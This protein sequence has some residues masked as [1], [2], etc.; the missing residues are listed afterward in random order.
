M[1]YFSAL[2]RLARTSCTPA[3]LCLAIGILAAAAVSSVVLFSGTMAAATVEIVVNG[4]VVGIYQSVVR[5]HITVDGIRGPV[6]IDI[7]AGG[8]AVTSADCP[9][10]ICRRTGRIH[11]AGAMIVCVPN[12]L[13][14]HL[15]GA[16]D[17]DA[18]LITY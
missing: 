4:Q 18:P 10:Q 2:W 17:P 1:K 8:V 6:E 12:H 7:D 16:P 14:V 3:D 11:R 5:R 9:Q 13:L 15:R